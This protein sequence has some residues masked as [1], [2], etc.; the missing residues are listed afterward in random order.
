MKRLICITIF[1]CLF[2]FFCSDKINSQIHFGFKTGIVFSKVGVD[3]N[4]EGTYNPALNDQMTNVSNLFVSNKLIPCFAV[5]F[6]PE[7]TQKAID[8][9]PLFTV[10]Q[11]PVFTEYN[12]TVNQVGWNN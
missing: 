5:A 3:Y 1:V 12:E 4:E 6:E 8:L 11:Q 10:N 2:G 7:Y 9:N